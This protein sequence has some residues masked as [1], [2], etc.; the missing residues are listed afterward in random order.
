ML[1]DT[2]C[3]HSSDAA[4]PSCVKYTFTDV[5]YAALFCSD[6]PALIDIAV[7]FADTVATTPSSPSPGGVVA[8]TAV[9][10]A[11]STPSSAT[12][13]SS[14]LPPAKTAS[15]TVI[16]TTSGVATAGG[17]N[18]FTQTQVS[19]SHVGGVGTAT[20][21]AKGGC[22]KVGVSRA[23]RLVGGFVLGGALIFA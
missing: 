3:K 19:G 22:G 8:A 23:L 10:I 15:N 18:P 21:V 2:L 11:R 17:P 1:T 16:A 13:T 12:Y 6:Q 5:S 4:S 20:P 7:T 9:A 14:S